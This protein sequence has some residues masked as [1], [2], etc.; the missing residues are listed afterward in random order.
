[1]GIIS[2]PLFATPASA[3]VKTEWFSKST[4]DYFN[5]QVCCDVFDKTEYTLE[6][7]FGRICSTLKLYGYLTNDN[8]VPW[9]ELLSLVSKHNDNCN[10]E[11]HFFCTDERIPYYFG[12]EHGHTYL[13]TFNESVILDNFCF[14]H[15]YDYP[16]PENTPEPEDEDE[17]VEWPESELESIKQAKAD[18]LYEKEHWYE[19]VSPND[20]LPQLNSAFG[21]PTGK[22]F[23]FYDSK[24][25]FFIESLYREKYLKVKS[26]IESL[27]KLGIKNTRQLDYF[28]ANLFFMGLSN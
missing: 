24:F 6:E 22:I 7:F 23:F 14:Q 28:R 4:F 18:L 12:F 20:L 5:Y 13:F 11:C 17:N 10:V 16:Y 1:M 25:T 3:I 26:E 9:S 19:Y 15:S 21:K 2:E 8:C 27:E